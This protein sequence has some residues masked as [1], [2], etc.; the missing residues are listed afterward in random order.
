MSA[1]ATYDLFIAYA[2]DDADWVEGFL[3]PELSLPPERVI[4]Q[5]DFRPGA[6]K[7]NEFER[8]VN[9][10]RYTVLVLTPAFLADVWSVYGSSLASYARV[11]YQ[12]DRLLPFI[13]QP[14][15]LP[16][17]LDTLTPLCTDASHYQ[18]GTQRLR[19]LL[20]QP[21]PILE[22]LSCPYPGMIAFNENDSARFFG[23]DEDIQYLIE[24]HLRS[25]PFVAIIGP[26]GSGKSSL[27]F[28]GLIPALDRSNYFGSGKWLIRV[29]RPGK[30]PL[31]TLNH[32]L[33]GKVIEDPNQ[34]I[35]EI[36][37]T[38]SDARQVLLVVDQFEELFAQ[39]SQEAIDFQKTL[40]NLLE[41]P[42]CYVV[43]TVR[44]DFYADLMTSLLW[45]KIQGHRKEVLPLNAKG[46]REAIVKPAENKGVFI[47]TALVE[48]L[49]ADA[50]GEPGIMPFI[51][52]TLV[53]LWNRLER[54][55]LP[56]KTYEALVLPDDAQG[57][58]KS[59]T[60]LQVAMARRA[61]MALADL[62]EEQQVIARRIFLRLIQF[63]EG[64]PDT[65]R[66]QTVKELRSADDVADGFDRTLEHF[67]I[68]RLLT[69]SATEADRAKDEDKVDIAHEALI[70]GWPKLRSWIEKRR[71]AEQV[72]RR[73]E[74]KVADWE[75][76]KA[77]GG[78]L[79]DEIG[80]HEAENWLKSPDAIELGYSKYF[81]ELISASR[82]AIKNELEKARETASKLRSRL[83]VAVVLA[84][85]AFS[86]AI[87][88]YWQRNEA[89][90]A[91]KETEEQRNQAEQQ[92]QAAEQAT[93]EAVNQKNQALKNQSLFFADLA[94]QENENFNFER[95]ML[96]ALEAL[97]K[98]LDNPEKPYVEEAELPLYQAL[99]NL[100]GRKILKGHQA[101]VNYVAFSPD[102]QQIATA[103]DD[104]TARLWKVKG[105]QT[106]KILKGHQSKVLH[107]AF[108]PDGKQ[109][110]TTSR[111]AT[112]RLWDV[113]QGQLLNTLTGHEFEVLNAAFSPDGKQVVTASS[114]TT[115]RLWDSH[116]SELLHT[117]EGHRSAVNHATFSPDGK[118]I[119]TASLDATARLWDVE[120]G[121]TLHS[122]TGHESSVLY[123]IFSP[124]GQQ[125]VTTSTDSTVRVWDV[126]EGKQLHVLTG[127]ESYVLNAAFSPDGQWLIT[128][129]S[130]DNTARLWDVNSGEL[131]NTLRGHE[132]S[133]KQADFSP[134]GLL[135]ITASEDSTA[136]L[137][138]AHSGKLLNI[139]KG[140]KGAVYHAAFSPDSNQVITASSDNT[141]RLWGVSNAELAITLGHEVSNFNSATFSLDSKLVALV[142]NKNR[143]QVL[144]TISGQQLTVLRHGKGHSV[145]YIEFSHDSKQIL[146]IY[147]NIIQLWDTRTGQ[148]F[149]KLDLA[150]AKRESYLNI[151]FA[152]FNHDGKQVIICSTEYQENKNHKTLWLWN[153]NSEQLTKIPMK[154][155]MD[156]ATL[157]FSKKWVLT[158]SKD[159][160]NK[161][162]TIRLWDI[163]NEYLLATLDHKFIIN[164]TTFRSDSK[165]I[166]LIGE[167]NLVWLW[168]IYK[169]KLTTLTHKNSVKSAKF[170]PDSKRIVTIIAGSN[171]VYLWDTNNAQLHTALKHELPVD[172]AIFSSNS[173]QLLTS[174]SEDDYFNE[175]RKKSVQ[176]WDVNNGQLLAILKNID[177]AIFSPNGE[178]ILTISDGTAQL[179]H[180]LP[181]NRSLVDYANDIKPYKLTETQR[182][183]LLDITKNYVLSTTF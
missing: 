99:V 80:L 14:C 135:L 145:D 172:F 49:V 50:A 120:S 164:S 11:K 25:H 166:L 156:Y 121:Q 75:R 9:Q 176:L 18:Q 31:T 161:S 78:G 180:H 90:R 146:T 57:T 86:A 10:S 55:F 130:T 8:A 107:V 138:D 46:L 95:A 102:G 150:R 158:I 63:G 117:L 60:G 19:E 151:D 62:S 81:P 61:D 29:M 179:W 32:L 154:F 123:A 52:E 13:R 110:V 3:I 139:F 96:L 72:R 67:V 85:L 106:S 6:D 175:N 27:V 114:D 109:L 103:S 129:D 65:R 105:D 38:Q 149:A 71:E 163:E 93:T 68:H 44:A 153:I 1:A 89:Q 35:V 101:A 5:E 66:Q 144:T 125:V 37:T 148:R 4:T 140:H 167:N 155:P 134:D 23:R 143:V 170:S 94:R 133:V 88:A 128:A 56:L 47:Q 174:S 87:G 12:Q 36:L 73:L 28:A 33:A 40:L 100:Y 92:K 91:Q 41:V 182:E 157:N 15:E 177:S 24:R 137:W 136:R 16:P 124:D 76:L 115:A 169:Q 98:S 70:N 142:Y 74:I 118:Q 162:S 160:E 20:A 141:A 111:D 108:S 168:D 82:E 21:E 42:H 51:Q 147:N 43:L 58:S 30:T 104:T 178:Q 53:L 112:A 127:H 132:F 171:I 116:S 165:Q 126:N 69:R 113:Q 64:R 39:A 48:R 181:I 119:V 183:Q 17:R 97:P 34:A 79:L 152:K 131:L 7:V 83:L 159:Y 77:K 122:L 2:S 59:L 54:R 26:S 22:S 84:M 45:P 173:Q